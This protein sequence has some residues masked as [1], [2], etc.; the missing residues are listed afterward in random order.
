MTKIGKIFLALLAITGISFLCLN[1]A[2]GAATNIPT[3]V[4]DTAGN[5]TINSAQLS[6]RLIDSGNANTTEMW[7]E[8]WKRENSG[9]I[10]EAG[11]KNIFNI[12][13]NPP[14][15]RG[16]QFAANI[17]G[18]EA[19]KVYCYRAVALN[20][21][22][23]STGE[24][25]CFTTAATERGGAPIIKTLEASSVS[26]NSAIL[27]G[28]IENFDNPTFARVYFEWYRQGYGWLKKQTTPKTIYT[29]S[30]VSENIGDLLPG[31]MYCYRMVAQTTYSTPLTYNGSS[32]YYQNYPYGCSGSDCL[33][34]PQ[35]NTSYEAG[36]SWLSGGTYWGNIYGEEK[37]FTTG[38]NYDGGDSDN[39]YKPSLGNY[40]TSNIQKNSADLNVELSSLGGDSQAYVWFEYGK[41]STGE[42]QTSEV[43]R[44][45]SGKVTISISSLQPSTTYRFRAFARNQDGTVSS[46]EKTFTTTYD[47][48]NYHRPSV[49][50]RNAT[51][52]ERYSAQLNGSLEDLGNDDNV[53]VWFE[54]GRNTGYGYET[55]KNYKSNTGD[56]SADISGLAVS[57]TYHFRAVARNDY[58]TVYGQD[59]TF[60]TNGEGQE[61]CSVPNIIT[62]SAIDISRYGATLQGSLDNMGNCSETEVWLE[63][64][65]DTNY[66]YTTS[67]KIRYYTGDYWAG[68]SGLSA[69][70]TYHFRA[71]AK[72]S[73]GVVY[74]DDRTFVTNYNGGSG[75]NNDYPQVR[76]NYATNLSRYG[77]TLNGTLEDLGDDNEAEVWFEYGR[78]DS[79][80]YTTTRQY[81]SSEGSFSREIYDLNSN[82][83]YHFRAVARND[84]GTVY[85]QDYTFTTKYSGGGDYEYRKPEVET[86]SASKVSRYTAT[87]NG[88]LLDLND[89]GAAEVWFEYGINN[90]SSYGYRTSS[91]TKYSAGNFSVE[92][93]NLEPNRTY[94]FR[95]AARNN[96]GTVYGNSRNF[97]TGNSYGNFD[98][99]DYHYDNYDN[100]YY[101]N[102]N[103]DLYLKVWAANLSQNQKVWNKTINALPSQRISFLVEAKNNGNSTI[104]NAILDIN[105]SPRVIFNGKIFIGSS[106]YYRS[107]LNNINL[108]DLA[109]G[110]RK[111]VIF[112]AA[113][114][115]VSNFGFGSNE[116]V[117]T[118]SIRNVYPNVSDNARIYVY[119]A[120]VAGYS[121]GPTSL[122]TGLAGKFT[123][124]FLI[125]C[126]IAFFA[127]FSFRK[128]FPTFL[129]KTQKMGEVWEKKNSQGE[130]DRKLNRIRIEG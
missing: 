124:F 28:R 11:R 8:Y 63:Y 23:R 51:E 99:Y 39:I 108:G 43:S 77:A 2:K 38:G 80:G 90:D 84:Y 29:V 35:P 81:R 129:A 82:T 78:E 57:A 125:P 50:T 102:Q 13:N 66:G 101:D 74:G 1:F 15:S 12:Y 9:D 112:E 92:L 69:D 72:T 7:F 75:Y 83:T 65:R 91:R 103:R 70:T 25:F 116:L 37:C 71:V 127:L 85:G 5:I 76:S 130:L 114:D 18:L 79:Y 59:Y 86:R 16:Y 47:Y 87:L 128:F 21:L 68:I 42:N 4:T 55:S 30:D 60:T 24:E 88:D 34:Y 113:L 96:Y 97:Y 100:Y 32:G 121:I 10:M 111:T 20:S 44:T 118:A 126:L 67:H 27:N 62:R 6:G 109:P 117:N 40:Y 41:N 53:Q 107:S 49:S 52:I 54:Y 36:G 119:K 26:N 105:L 31:K 122:T 110:Q 48:N 33:R 115:P 14:G 123:D 61:N 104:K 17:R 22:G 98:D 45:S 106:S 19:G 46:G 64:G 89:S 58:G 73:A 95:A 120:G 56:F 94:Y 93:D 3:V